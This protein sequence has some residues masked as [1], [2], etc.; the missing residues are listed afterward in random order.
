MN[1]TLAVQMITE[2]EEESRI[3]LRAAGCVGGKGGGSIFSSNKL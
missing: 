1:S 2:A 3:L